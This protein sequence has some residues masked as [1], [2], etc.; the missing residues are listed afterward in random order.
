MELNVKKLEQGPVMAAKGDTDFGGVAKAGPV[1]VDTGHGGKLG[2]PV[3]TSGN[4]A[5][6]YQC[7]F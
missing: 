3:N 2:G 5:V 6:G 1:V 4:P 7:K